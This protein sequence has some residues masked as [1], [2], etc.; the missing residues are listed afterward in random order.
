MTIILKSIVYFFSFFT[1]WHRGQPGLHETFSNKENCHL[2]TRTHERFLMLC[3]KALCSVTP[4]WRWHELI[5]SWH[6]LYAVSLVIFTRE[7][8]SHMD[9]SHKKQA[10]D[11][12]GCSKSFTGAGFNHKAKARLRTEVRGTVSQKQNRRSMEPAAVSVSVGL[13]SHRSFCLCR[14]CLLCTEHLYSAI[15]FPFLIKIL[16][17]FTT[18]FACV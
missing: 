7:D 5:P 12:T 9:L 2:F 4:M 11:Y 13:P 8:G 17:L 14:L 6:I 15:A 18:V 3:W 10:G 1:P 16:L